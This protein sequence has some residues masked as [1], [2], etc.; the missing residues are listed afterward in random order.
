MADT[1]EATVRCGSCGTQLEWQEEIG[2][3]E[4]VHCKGCGKDCGTFHDIKQ[5]AINAVATRARELIGQ[6]FNGR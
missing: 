2:D 4:H 1:V 3:G 6:V 5:A